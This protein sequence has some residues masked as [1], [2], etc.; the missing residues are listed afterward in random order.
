M[1]NSE[2]A[3]GVVGGAGASRAIAFSFA[4]SASLADVA[5]EIGR[6]LPCTRSISQSVSTILKY[7]SLTTLLAPVFLRRETADKSQV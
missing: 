6:N 1:P 5:Q 3:A 2:N 4:F 7:A